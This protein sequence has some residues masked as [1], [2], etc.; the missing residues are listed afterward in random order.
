MKEIG[1]TTN[2][3]TMENSSTNNQATQ[4]IPSITPICLVT[5]GSNTLVN[6]RMVNSRDLVKLFSVM[7]KNLLV[8]GRTER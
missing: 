8:S 7:E 5:H 2:L 1:Q 4:E 6:F 3:A